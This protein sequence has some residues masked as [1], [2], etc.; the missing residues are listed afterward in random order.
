MGKNKFRNRSWI[1][2]LLVSLLVIIQT[3]AFGYAADNPRIIP[4]QGRLT[5]TSG[6]PLN[7]VY[8][9]Y[10]TIWDK[11][12]GG[13]PLWSEIHSTVSVINGQFNVLLGTMTNLDDPDNNGDLGD[14]VGFAEPRFLGIKVGADT[15]QEMVPPPATGAVVSCEKG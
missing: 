3:V 14:A 6:N 4:F 5:D 13:N 8:T 9:I 10:F 2:P 12:T 11:P 1:S 15:N 7:D